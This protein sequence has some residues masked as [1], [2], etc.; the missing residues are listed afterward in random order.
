[1]SHGMAPP[2]DTLLKISPRLLVHSRF[3]MPNPGRWA[4]SLFILCWVAGCSSGK[5]GL[6]Q[7]IARH[8]GRSTTGTHGLVLAD[9]SDTKVTNDDLAGLGDLGDL[10]GIVL[11]HTAIDNR[12]LANL[13]TATHLQTIDLSNTQVSDAGLER[14]ATLGSLKFVVLEGCPVSQVAIDNLQRTLPDAVIISDPM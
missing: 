10:G 3:S 1:M 4:A 9:F 13:K 7:L 11:R 8:G 12:G 5:S 2:G 14:L 6:P